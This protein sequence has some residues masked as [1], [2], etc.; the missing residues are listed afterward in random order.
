MVLVLGLSS[1]SPAIKAQNHIEEEKWKLE[2]AYFSNLYR[3]DYDGVLALVHPQFL[4][5]PGNLPRPIGK[6][7]SARF[8]KQLIP[9][10]TACVVRME[11]CGLQRSGDTV[12]T[13][14]LLHVDCPVASGRIQTHSSRTT[15]TWTRLKG[16]WKL[17]GGM[18]IDVKQ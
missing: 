3:A 13:Q 1:S 5:W 8:M 10:P 11:R 7:E 15:H 16:H 12:L 18:S 17:F 4:G 6:N 14:Y 2:E 9:Q